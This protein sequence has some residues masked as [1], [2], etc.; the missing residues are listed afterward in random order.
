[1]RTI[2]IINT[3]GLYLHCVF[4]LGRFVGHDVSN[5]FSPD[6]VPESIRF[7]AYTFFVLFAV[8]AVLGCVA[9]WQGVGWSRFLVAV[10]LFP[11]MVIGSLIWAGWWIGVI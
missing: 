10:I 2:F 3:V 11:P 4:V 1:M 7:R 8:F 9:L 5:P 6:T